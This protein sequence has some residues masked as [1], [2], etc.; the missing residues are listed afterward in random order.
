M[1]RARWKAP[2]ASRVDLVGAAEVGGS[3][4]AT[5]GVGRRR[6]RAEEEAGEEEGGEEEGSGG[7]G[8]EERGPACGR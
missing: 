6:G 7:G 2:A 4:R 1:E 3:L 5:L 8:E